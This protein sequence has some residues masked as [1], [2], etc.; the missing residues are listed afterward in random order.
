MADILALME[1]AFAT[2][3]QETTRFG[4][5][6]RKQLNRFLN[7]QKLSDKAKKNMKTGAAI[8]M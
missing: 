7:W 2:D 8:M 4:I 3:M 5:L 1:V 6:T